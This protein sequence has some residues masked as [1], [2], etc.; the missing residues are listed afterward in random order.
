M[1]RTRRVRIRMLPKTSL[2][3]NERV[4]GGKPVCFRGDDVMKRWFEIRW[5]G[6]V[7]SDLGPSTVW[8]GK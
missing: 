5:S 7:P 8:L 4:D 1:V 6:F 2:T 3:M